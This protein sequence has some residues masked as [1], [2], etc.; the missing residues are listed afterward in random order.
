MSAPC[1]VHDHGGPVR[2]DFID[3]PT[4]WRIQ[5]EGLTHVDQRCSAA[6]TDGAMLCDCAALRTEWERRVATQAAA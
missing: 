5:C 6:Q 2:S 1:T 3:F 4:G